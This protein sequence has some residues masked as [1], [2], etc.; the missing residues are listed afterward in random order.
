[1]TTIRRSEFESLWRDIAD[2]GRDSVRGGYSRHV[3]DD[4]DI[5]LREW[6]VGAA[7]GRG[8][9]VET[10]RNG[11]LWAWWRRQPGASEDNALVTGSHLDSV[12]GGGAFDGPLGVVSALLAVDELR[13]CGVKPTRP[14]AIVCFAE[15]EGGRFGL[16]CLGSRLL[17]GATDPDVARALTDRDGVILADAAKRAGVDPK[18]F[19]ADPKRLGNIGDFIELHVEQGRLMHTA[20]PAAAVGIASSIVAHGRWRISIMGD[21]NHAG[22]T[23]IKDRRDPMIVAA[24]TILAARSVARQ[25]DG[26]VATVGRL[27]PIPGGTNVIASQVNLW[28]DTRYGDTADTESAVASILTRAK[29]HAA[30]EGCTIE[31]HQESASPHVAFDTELR[32]QLASVVPGPI[33]PTGAGH[34]AGVLAEH[35]RTA[36]LFVRNPTGISHAPGEHAEVDDCVAGVQALANTLQLLAVIPAPAHGL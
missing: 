23:A 13:A 24:N 21:G 7:G 8:L 27:E 34:D 4:A 12:P 25:Y 20:D 19:G 22:T 6:F 26:A 10:D 17:T 11:N 29:Q 15:E 28:L 9:D 35:T 31:V 36:M 18:H 30:N 2:I 16:P 3:F 32:G 5:A 14:L 1:M 33:V